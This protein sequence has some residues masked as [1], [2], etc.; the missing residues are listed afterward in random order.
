MKERKG[1][2]E[3]PTRGSSIVVPL[4]DRPKCVGC[5]SPS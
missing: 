3:T 5:V 4:R 1:V 2:N